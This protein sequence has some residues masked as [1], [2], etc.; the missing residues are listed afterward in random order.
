M[1]ELR[2][3]FLMEGFGSKDRHANADEHLNIYEALE[4][5]NTAVAIALLSTH[6][7]TARDDAIAPL[8]HKRPAST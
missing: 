4:R 5:G 8:P 1:N 7:D 2:L 6:L 3:C